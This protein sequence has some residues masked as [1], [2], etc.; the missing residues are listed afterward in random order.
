MLL[1][2]ETHRSRDNLEW[3]ASFNSAHPTWATV[4]CWASFYSAQPA[5]VFKKLFKISAL[6]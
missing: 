5:R 6:P 2:N 4:R 3:C 1:R